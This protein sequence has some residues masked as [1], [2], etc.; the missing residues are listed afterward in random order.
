MILV[1]VKLNKIYFFSFYVSE[2]DLQHLLMPPLHSS[3]WMAQVNFM[4]SAECFWFTLCIHLVSKLNFLWSKIAR[5]NQGQYVSWQLYWQSVRYS[6][7]SC[8]NLCPRSLGGN[9][10]SKWK[11]KIGQIRL[12]RWERL[13]FPW[14]RFAKL[15]DQPPYHHMHRQ[16]VETQSRSLSVPDLWGCMDNI[17]NVQFRGWCQVF[18]LGS[19]FTSH[20]EFPVTRWLN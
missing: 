18:K 7:S 4:S 5:T 10:S 2:I 16:C 15:I 19:L 8:L 1:Y 17:P 12:N 6:P 14:R 13:R 20:A 3:L 9:C 11:H